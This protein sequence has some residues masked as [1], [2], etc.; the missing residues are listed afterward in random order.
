MAERRSIIS[1][2]KWPS[3][4]FFAVSLTTG[5]PLSCYADWETGM[6]S[7]GRNLLTIL[8]VLSIANYAILLV[9]TQTKKRLL[10]IIAWF[11]LIPQFLLLLG[12]M[13]TGSAAG[14]IAFFF[15]VLAVV[16]NA[17]TKTRELQED[18][19]PGQQQ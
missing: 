4:L 2:N 14:F 17:L 9:N 5:L 8:M 12:G 13:L 7:S 15:F 18:I 3:A 10:K 11:L 1:K 19:A 16:I 6:A